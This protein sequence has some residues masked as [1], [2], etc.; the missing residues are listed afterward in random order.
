MKVVDILFLCN[1]RVHFQAR[2]KKILEVFELVC[3]PIKCGHRGGHGF[4]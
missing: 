2:L 1:V 3:F 4:G